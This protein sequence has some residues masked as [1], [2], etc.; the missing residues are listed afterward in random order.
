MQLA[1]QQVELRT[2]VADLAR[3]QRKADADVEQVKS[4][5]SRNEQRLAAGQVSSPRD[6]EQLQHEVGALDRRIS[7]LEDAELDIMERLESSQ[8]NL[9]LV[10]AE[11]ADTDAEVAELSS[12][13][14][15]AVRELDEQARSA[16]E[17]RGR[18]V[19]TVPDPLLASYERV[20]AH[21]GD[22]AAAALKRRRCEGCRLELTAADLAEIAAAPSDEVLRCPECNRILVR[23]PD[24]GL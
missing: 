16:A 19:D 7:T 2:E 3:E 10:T 23:T 12:A 4:R 18:V 6:L 9:E 17:E 8:R 13:R 11:L 20:R 1:R 5:R 15:D 22:S 24:S 14:D 21:T